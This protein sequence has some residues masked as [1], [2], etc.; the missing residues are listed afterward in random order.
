MV[1]KI[2]E[3]FIPAHVSKALSS[4]NSMP[5]SEKA[6]TTQAIEIHR[7][8]LKV[9]LPTRDVLM[10]VEIIKGYCYAIKTECLYNLVLQWCS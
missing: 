2:A 4:Q 7:R 8:D 10:A 9:L 5:M 1:K 3:A 6:L